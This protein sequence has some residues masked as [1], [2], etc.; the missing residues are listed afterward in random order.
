MPHETYTRCPECRTVFRVTPPQLALR[1]GQ[2]R[3]GHCRVVFDGRAQAISLAPGQPEAPADP[4]VLGPPTV[5]LRSARSLEPPLGE[6]AA[7]A[8][9]PSFERDADDRPGPDQAPHDDKRGAR[10]HLRVLYAAAIPLLLLLLG[11]QV[12][13]HYRDAFAARWPA[14]KPALVRLCA[15]AGCAIT[16]LRD[17]AGLAI[18]ASDLQADPAH[19]GLLVLSATIRNRAAVALAYPHLEMTLTDVDDRVVVRR[20]LAPS[21]Y[22]GGTADVASGIP[23]NAEVLVRLFVDASATR[24]AGYRLFLFYP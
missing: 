22:A 5:T 13:F 12:L 6:S 16:P 20:A 23:A 4:L 10:R 18:D 15:V 9:E 3:C 7:P 19:R 14:A 17:V 2:V 21:E 11:G 8:R 24:Q 1:D